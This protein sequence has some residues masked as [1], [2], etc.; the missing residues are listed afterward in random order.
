MP[1]GAENG[2]DQNTKLT[3]PGK[4]PGTSPSTSPTSLTC[5]VDD[6]QTQE[7]QECYKMSMIRFIHNKLCNYTDCV[8]K[9]KPLADYY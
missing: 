6:M 3:S 4:S 1:G 9:P 5:Y 2:E 8:A 7:C